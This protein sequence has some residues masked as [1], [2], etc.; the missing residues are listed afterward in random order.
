MEIKLYEWNS[1][2]EEV[3]QEIDYSISEKVFLN[4]TI[5]SALVTYIKEL[6]KEM[7]DWHDNRQ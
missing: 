3:G 4:I 6:K 7:S 1:F 5:D 2:C